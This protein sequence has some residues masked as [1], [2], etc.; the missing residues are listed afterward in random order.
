ME[1]SVDISL[2]RQ[3]NMPCVIVLLS[4]QEETHVT[5]YMT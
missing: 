1:I 3:E 2:V 4:L 5:L